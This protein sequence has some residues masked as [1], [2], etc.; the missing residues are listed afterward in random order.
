M[1]PMAHKSALSAAPPPA[2][3]APILAP[4][5]D[6]NAFGALIRQRRKALRLTQVKLGGLSGV[7]HKFI[8]EIERGKPTAEIG[9]LMRVAQMLGIDLLARI[10]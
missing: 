6:A 10:R 4:L 5:P 3:G 7:S 1:K 2:N 8:N 9:K